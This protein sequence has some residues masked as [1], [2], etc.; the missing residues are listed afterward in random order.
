MQKQTHHRSIDETPDSHPEFTVFTK[1]SQI[2]E[3]NEGVYF[4]RSLKCGTGVASIERLIAKT[5]PLL[6]I[7]VKWP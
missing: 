2:I 5:N 1:R 6:G 4:R 7:A 3:G